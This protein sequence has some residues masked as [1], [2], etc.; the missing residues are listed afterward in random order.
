MMAVRILAL[1]GLAL[2][3]SV[4]PSSARVQGQ[5]YC[6]GYDSEFPVPCGPEEEEEEAQPLEAG[7]S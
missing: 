4:L 3:G 7:T 5:M 2:S 6:W 1:V